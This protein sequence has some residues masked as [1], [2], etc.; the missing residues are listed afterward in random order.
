MV[1]D[2]IRAVFAAAGAEGRL[3]AVPVDTGADGATE[4]AVGADEPVVLAS[5]MKILLVLEFARQAAAGQLD[6]RERVRV[7]AA[8][9]LGGWGTAGCVDDIE[10]SLRDLAPYFAPG[11]LT[12]PPPARPETIG[13]LPE[14]DTLAFQVTAGGEGPS[15]FF[16]GASDFSEHAARGLRPDLAMVAVPASA[17]THR[18]VPRLLRALGDPGVVVPVHWDDFERPLDLP[19]SPDPSADVEAFT[20]QVRRE[21]PAARVVVPDYRTVYD[22]DMRPTS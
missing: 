8:D 1:E 14:G 20:A 10:L 22:A 17:S 12:G 19:P 2:E 3:H 18:Y 4:V 7:G 15:A 16:M 13:D 9:R 21:S 6:P 5:I 11:S